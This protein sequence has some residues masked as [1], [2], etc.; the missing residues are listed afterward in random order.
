LREGIDGVNP[1]D[2]QAVFRVP[3]Q[4]LEESGI[5]ASYQ[6]LGCYNVL[7]FDSTEHFCIATAPVIIV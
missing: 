1:K 5:M 7:L 2:I 6:V 4:V 3:L